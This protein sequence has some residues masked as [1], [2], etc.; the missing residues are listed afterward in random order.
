MDSY[1]NLDVDVYG[2]SVPHTETESETLSHAAQRS[3]DGYSN[4]AAAAA[5]AGLVC[6]TDNSR[7][8]VINSALHALIRRLHVELYRYAPLSLSLSMPSILIYQ[9]PCSLQPSLI[10]ISVI[11]FHYRLSYVQWLGT[12]R[13]WIMDVCC[14]R[15]GCHGSTR[16]S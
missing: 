12:A 11:S 2:L 5:A 14:V 16:L 8:Q 7:H 9:T 6:S 15:Y 4:P 3:L 1:S 13:R 10:H